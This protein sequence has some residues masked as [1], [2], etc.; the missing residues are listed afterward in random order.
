MR[1]RY[2]DADLHET[3]GQILYESEGIREIM[4][5]VKRKDR[6]KGSGNTVT[7]KEIL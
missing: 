2:R 5:P 3:K 4:I 1:I 6:N 7:E